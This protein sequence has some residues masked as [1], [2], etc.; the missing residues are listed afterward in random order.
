MS[1]RSLSRTY[2]KVENPEGTFSTRICTDCAYRVG[3][4]C[5]ICD[6]LIRYLDRC[7]DGY[8][9]ELCAALSRD[10]IVS[11]LTGKHM[12]VYYTWQP[13]KPNAKYPTRDRT[14]EDDE[15]DDEYL[16]A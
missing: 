8:T 15:D 7:P 4:S 10:S 6:G 13:K 16:N 3:Q 1:T 12:N 9:V 2:R 5:S 14:I 11:K